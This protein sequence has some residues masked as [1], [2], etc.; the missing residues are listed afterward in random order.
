MSSKYLKCDGCGDILDRRPE[1]DFGGSNRNTTGRG[2]FASG[3]WHQLLAYAKS[4]GWTIIG[5]EHDG[6]HFCPKHQL[7]SAVER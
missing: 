5:D 2:T 6:R 7:P 1:D 4:L 3:E